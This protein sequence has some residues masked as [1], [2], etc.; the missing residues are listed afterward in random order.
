[1][2]DERATAVSINYPGYSHLFNE[3][4]VADAPMW[5]GLFCL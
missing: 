3:T 4:G 5:T 1:M 2:D